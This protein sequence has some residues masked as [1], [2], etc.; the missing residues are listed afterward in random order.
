MASTT[1]EITWLLVVLSALHV[2]HPKVALLFYDNQTALHIAANPA[3]HEKTK[4]IEID[5]HLVRDKIQA[6]VIQ[7]LH[8]NSTH[9]LSDLLTK[10]L[11]AVQLNHLLSKMG[12][13]NI[14]TP[15]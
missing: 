11:S 5:C 2:D 3:F 10:P 14:Y 15:S 9:Q 4:H 7:T 6:G 8:V 1:C 13:I 12:V